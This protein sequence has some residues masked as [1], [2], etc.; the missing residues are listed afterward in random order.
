VFNI[1]HTFIVNEH[2]RKHQVQFIIW[3]LIMKSRCVT[4][5]KPPFSSSKTI[6]E[7][8]AILPLSSVKK[9]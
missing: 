1:K 7:K 9:E 5:R 4:L 2:A 6:I 3:H 8:K